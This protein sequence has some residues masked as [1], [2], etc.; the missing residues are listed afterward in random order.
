MAGSLEDLQD[1]LNKAAKEMPDKA[2]RIIGVEG[3]K[4]IKKNFRDQGFNDTGLQKWQKRKTTDKNGR[5]I[6]R[7]IRGRNT[8]GVTKFG[9]RNADRA[10]L[11]GH[12]TGGDK[13]I[14]SFSSNIIKASS[15][16]HFR[17]SKKYAGRHNEGL[18]GMPQRQFMGKSKYL[19]NQISQKIK[20]ELDKLLR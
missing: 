11:V 15:Q 7:Y 18:D 10:I 2:L 5:D 4:F 1:L 8:G 9:L 3:L 20:K 19:D 6:T 17:S 13:L 14:N 16:V 12:D